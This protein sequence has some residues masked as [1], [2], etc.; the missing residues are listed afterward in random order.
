MY[1][2]NVRTALI[3]IAFLWLI[4][5]YCNCYSAVLTSPIHLSRPTAPACP[6][7]RSQTDILVV[8]RTDSTEAHR[9]LPTLFNTVLKCIPDYVIYSDVEEEI[10]GHHVHDILDQ[11]DDALKNTIQEVDQYNQLHIRTREESKSL[12]SGPERVAEDQHQGPNTWKFIP[13]IDRAAKHRPDAKWFIFIEADTYILWQNLLDYLSKFDAERP[14]YLGS[15]MHIGDVLFA[16]GG[17]AFALS[18]PAIKKISKY[19]R[20][21]HK[22]WHRYTKEQWAGEWIGDMIAGKALKEEGIDLVWTF[23]YLQ[24]DNLATFEWNT[25]KSDQRPQC[26]AP[27]T[28]HR[29]S[30]A[31]FSKMWQFEQERLRRDHAEDLLHYRDIFKRLVY[32]EIQA[33]RRSWD[34]LSFG[35]EYSDV[36][37]K[38][39]SDGKRIGLSPEERIA[40]FSFENC[41][42]ACDS[43][44]TCIQFSFSPGK[45]MVS[46]ELR[47]GYSE[48]PRPGAVDD[49][50]DSGTPGAIQ[51]GW[52]MRR[53]A[54]YM[55]ELDRSCDGEKGNH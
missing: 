3:P 16:H 51:S 6:K 15:H 32:P 34:N 8:I 13:M 22:E 18:N 5:L 50:A 12:K 23:P 43:I 33:R 40:Q 30:G 54:S 17:P 41:Q 31:E 53:V 29:M 47:L 37:F 55:Q 39:F 45:C 25:L 9:K 10:E 20:G 2:H 14:Y 4:I 49:N 1:S 38:R 46:D 11:V 44:P 52:I 42:I 28:F 7:S 48:D 36:S 35:T 27:L 24:G 26:S 21:H 19:W